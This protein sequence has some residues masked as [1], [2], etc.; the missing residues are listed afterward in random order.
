MELT[1]DFL[2]KLKNAF[3]MYNWEGNIRELKSYIEFLGFTEEK[4][5]RI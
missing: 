3:E 4:I 1:L 5:N 2:L